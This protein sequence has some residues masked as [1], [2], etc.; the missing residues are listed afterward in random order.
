MPD[1]WTYKKPE[2][3][4][5][6][7]C[8]DCDPASLRPA[9]YP[10]PRCRSHHLAEKRRRRL[11][12]AGRRVESTYGLSP[13]QYTELKAFQGDRCA[14]CQRATG[15]TKMLAVDHDHRQAMIDG[16]DPKKGCPK[17]VRGLVCGPCNDILGHLRDDIEAAR[18][19]VFY[20]T[21]PPWQHI[22]DFTP[23][24]TWAPGIGVRV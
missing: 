14:I 22:D 2:Q 15:A 24:G 18:R 20:L 5:G 6:K 13:E 21:S 23:R 4:P 8:K 9:P 10:G 1:R 12:A 19:L 3:T 11:A 16:H 17:C 7:R